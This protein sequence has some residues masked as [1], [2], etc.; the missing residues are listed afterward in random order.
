M[1]SLHFKLLYAVY[2]TNCTA[3]IF[4][5]LSACFSSFLLCSSVSFTVHFHPSSWLPPRNLPPPKLKLKH[6]PPKPQLLLAFISNPTKLP[7]RSL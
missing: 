2:G 4:F 5:I 3:P 1:V 7:T 6:P